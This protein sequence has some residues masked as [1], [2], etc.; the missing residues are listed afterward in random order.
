[1]TGL[2][3]V[4]IYFMILGIPTYFHGRQKIEQFNIWFDCSGLDSL[5][6]TIT[7]PD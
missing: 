3:N 5:L 1:M 4:S 2:Y 6:E 7:S